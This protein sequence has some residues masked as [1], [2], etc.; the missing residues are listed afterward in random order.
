MLA[1]KE[2]FKKNKQKCLQID[3]KLNEFF[4]NM[5]IKNFICGRGIIIIQA[6][7]KIVQQLFIPDI[8]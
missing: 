5:E 2:N 3:K 4:T 7:K 1:M 6:Q 8:I